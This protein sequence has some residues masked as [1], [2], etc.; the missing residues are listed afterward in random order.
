VKKPPPILFVLPNIFTVSSIFCGFYAITIAIN[1]NAADRFYGA[2]VAILFG[3]LFDAADGRVA[4]MTK[5][6]SDFGVQLDS[7]ADV[8][9][10]G[11]APA[12]VAYQWSL[13][14]YGIIGLV[15]AFLY[16]ACG[17]IR[18]AR[19][20]IMAVDPSKSSR[21]FLGLPIPLAASTLMSLVMVH[22]RNI[23]GGELVSP[24]LI[25]AVVLILAALM[26]SRVHYRT[27]K[28]VKNPRLILPLV[29]I[30][31][32]L[33]VVAAIK[34]S[35]SLIFALASAAF[36]LYGLI[37]EVVRLIR[38]RVLLARKHDEEKD[39]VY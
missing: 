29:I 1:G 22:H 17:A 33:L 18:L 3:V 31:A 15:A 14:Q 20:N 12:V 30:M 10:F 25:L 38:K 35:F 34:T 9:T 26:V 5:T 19:F 2:A 39:E 11:L 37:E 6:Q 21:F 32:S 23:V 7:L 4:R 27:F 13:A 8:V 36:L 28:R 24:P 16:V